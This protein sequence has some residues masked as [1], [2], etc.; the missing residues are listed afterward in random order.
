LITAKLNAEGLNIMRTWQESLAE[1]VTEY[2]E[3][4][5]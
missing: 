1:Y 4:F 3:F 2:K 5:S